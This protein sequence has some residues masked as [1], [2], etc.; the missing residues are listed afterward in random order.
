M[1]VSI[2]TAIHEK[3]VE[4][5]EKVLAGL[6][7]QQADQAVIVHDRSSEAILDLTRAS[8]QAIEGG[9]R[10]QASD[11]G[12]V[13]ILTLT[14]PPG[15]RSP[16]VSF[17][18]G[19]D[20]V[21][22]DVT[23]L[24]HSDI[25][26]APGNVERVRAH[27][28]E[29]PHSVL[30]GQVVESNPERL[31]G[32]GNAGPLLMGTRNPRPLTWCMAA[33]T[34]ALRQ[35]GGWDEAYMQGVC[36]EDD[37]L[38]CRLWKAGLDFHFVDDFLAIHETHSRAYFNSYRMLPNMTTFIGRYGCRSSHDYVL[39]SKPTVLTAPGRLTWKHA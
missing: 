29:H 8:R 2:L 7:A 6:S 20:A 25:V 1:K 15:W 36:Y 12:G 17:N 37:D 19:L 34:A 22:G 31:T 4:T 39:R 32:A 3:P 35:I 18:A 10:G 38:T 16:C 33:P 9:L 24:S 23:L 30:F 21:T 14:G 5:W 26:Q 13:S 28:S 27:F 11:Y